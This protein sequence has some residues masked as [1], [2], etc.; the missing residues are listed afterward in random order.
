MDNVNIFLSIM[1]AVT[2]NTDSVSVAGYYLW[3]MADLI[4]SLMTIVGTI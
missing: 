4:I 2:S 3:N 1:M